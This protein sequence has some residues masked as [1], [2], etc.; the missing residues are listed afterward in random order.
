[1]ASKT[2]IYLGSIGE[3]VRCEID[4]AKGSLAYE[5]TQGVVADRAQVFRRE[6]SANHQ[7]REQRKQSICGWPTPGGHCRSGQAI[8]SFESAEGCARETGVL[9]KRDLEQSRGAS[10]PYFILLQL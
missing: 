10:S 1:M 9:E 4:S 3:L 2:R 6:L 5:A 8:L 7:I